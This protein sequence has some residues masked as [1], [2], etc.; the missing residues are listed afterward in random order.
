MPTIADVVL[1]VRVDPSQVKKDVEKGVADVDTSKAGRSAG[2]SFGDGMAGGMD[3]PLRAGQDRYVKSHD[4]AGK[5]AGGLFSK[6][7]ASKLEF[8]KA[9]GAVGGLVGFGDA[10]QAASGKTS[11]FGRVLAGV[12]LATGVLEPAVAGL[13]VTVMGLS[14][15]MAAT[16]IGAGA[17]G[18]A[19]KSLMTSI[20]DLNKLQQQAATGNKEAVKQLNKMLKEMP[21]AVVNFAE[22]LKGAKTDYREWAFSLA[23]P[24]LAP[25]QRGLELITPF[26]QAISPLVEAASRAFGRLV[27]ELGKRIEGGG[28][29]NFVNTVLPH[30]ERSI[31]NLG[32]SFGNITAGIWGVLKAFLPVSAQI[33]GGV[34]KLTQHFK[35]WANSLPSHTGFQSLMRMFREQAPAAGEVLKN[36]VTIFT[37]IAGALAGI[38]TPAN[39]ML[40]LNL[41]MPL[42][43]LMATL[44]ANKGLVQTVT[45]FMMFHKVT[46]RMVPSLTSLYNGFKIAS[47]GT[48]LLSGGMQG[49]K[50]AFA[51][52]PIGIIVTGLTLLAAALIVAWQRS[53]TFRNIVKG[54]WDAIKNSALAVVNWFAGPFVNFF[55]KTIPGAF[56]AVLNWVKANWPYLVGA[57]GGPVGLAVA[58]ITKH[59]GTVT[60]VFKQVWDTIW[61]ATIGPMINFFTKT[62]PNMIGAAITWLKQNWPLILG[63]LGGPVG[64]AVVAIV[65][66]WDQIKNAFAAAWQWIVNNVGAPI[67]TF[68]T[69]TLPGW[70]TTAYRFIVDR[71]WTPVKDAF[72]LAWQWIYTNVL[73][74]IGTF[75]SKTLT[76]WL[77]TA[78]RFIV[79]KFWTPVKTAFQAAWQW[80]YTNVLSPIGTFFSTTLTGWLTTA[81]R[82]IVDRFWTPVKNA[83]SS[84]W[85]WIYTNV[86]SP[87][88]T[89]FTST[90][91]GWLD[92]AIGFVNSKFVTPFRNA[93]KGAWDWVVTNVWNPVKTFLTSTI[94]GWFDTAVGAIKTAWNK[95]KE[96]AAAPVRFIVNTV[97]DDGIIKGFN[98]VLGWLKLPQIPYIP[99]MQ[100]GGRLPG[101]G[102][103]DRRLILAEDGET[104]VS[105]ET[106]REMAP[107]FAAYGV[108]GYQFGGIIGSIVGAI[109]GLGSALTLAQLA[110]FIP[111]PQQAAL[112]LLD[113]LAGTIK[114]TPGTGS[115]ADAVRAGGTKVL[116]SVLD[117]A[118]SLVVDHIRK[119][120]MDWL[121]SLIA[122][123]PGS[124]GSWAKAPPDV[125]AAQRYALEQVKIMWPNSSATNYSALVALWNG[126]SGWRWNATNPT[127]GAYGIPQALP[128]DKMSA[129]G[130]DWRTN[131][132]T[133]IEW[134]LDYIKSRYGTPCAAWSF[135]QAQYPHWYLAS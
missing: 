61:S 114:G 35:D 111:G 4:N 113:S 14:A 56:Q 97:L 83:F 18:L 28:L 58:Y 70:L 2:A 47:S 131:P 6:G 7:F 54:T 23:K 116:T 22:S 3:P 90:L 109:P 88:K 128:A 123:A 16:G 33:D 46:D 132:A 115:W 37:N 64:L 126:E 94:S 59:W 34:L 31:Y 51:A 38:T 104:V 106:S 15:S 9:A 52:N 57:L 125:A 98:V 24:V 110:K 85:T 82:F 65:K 81:Y 30:V 107:L 73:S 41:L 45:L 122:P 27:G 36:L 95:V 101:Y 68:F 48:S 13:T 20:K 134:G 93:I 10:A 112:K 26:L 62:I 74:P 11:M 78:Y 79:D 17:Y 50:A 12:N 63:I 135:W 103:G 108:P 67:N 25:L 5:Q 102:G 32:M 129:A 124:P 19:L 105:K 91:P 1:R 55:T 127:S 119:P 133:Q 71:F 40:L 77:T 53:E 96:I 118:K 66:Y 60:G 117:K 42:T 87:V 100:A 99:R 130:S 39:S 69:K 86:W 8:P 121:K 80:I 44:S 72:S 43:S 89:F 21:P 84:A 75:F 29:Q 76:G 49:L 92:T 120:V